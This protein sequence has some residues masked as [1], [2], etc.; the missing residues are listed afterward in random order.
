MLLNSI[1][2]SKIHRNKISELGFD[3]RYHTHALTTA[4]GNTYYFCYDLGYA[5]VGQESL[6]IIRK[7][8]KNKKVP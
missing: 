1:G 5:F 4:A 7:P 2:K 6:I 8:D 3:F